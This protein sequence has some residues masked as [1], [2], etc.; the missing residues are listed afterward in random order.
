MELVAT[1]LVD[2]QRTLHE[3]LLEQSSTNNLETIS[4]SKEMVQLRQCS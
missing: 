2:M 3:S 4:P 1:V